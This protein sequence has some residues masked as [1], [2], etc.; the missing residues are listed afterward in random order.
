MIEWTRCAVPRILQIDDLVTLSNQL[1]EKEHY[2]PGETHN[3]WEIVFI[4]SG[5]V[6]VTADS[7]VYVVESGNAIVHAPMEFHSIWA[8]QDTAPERVVLSFY[9]EKMPKLTGRMFRFSPE[10][11]DEL[12]RLC[13]LAKT[14]FTYEAS[15]IELTRIKPGKEMAAA[16]FLCQV[17][18]V[19]YALLENK[20][21][22]Y[23]VQT[24]QSTKNYMFILSVLEQN[25]YNKLTVADVARLC[26]MSESN[27]KKIFCKF[28]GC[29][30]IT[31]FNTLKI[32][33]A[34]EHIGKGMSIKEAAALF[35]FADQNYFSTVFK[36]I[37][38]VSPAK[39]K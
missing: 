25:I 36:R 8:E 38:G 14:I 19:M 32:K 29:G 39:Y 27:L 22:R 2:F 5:K 7:E 31:Y 15:E 18:N 26:S 30:I 34:A 13:A 11:A 10:T 1:L 23:T 21:D 33:K 4:L 9:A 24:S 3:F 16:S 28:A 12:R 37:M 6:G 17:E 35:G 20:S